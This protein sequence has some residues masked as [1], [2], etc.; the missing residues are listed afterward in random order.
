MPDIDGEAA[1]ILI[2][3]GCDPL[4]AA[5]ASTTPEPNSEPTGHKWPRVWVWIGAI[6]GVIAALVIHSALR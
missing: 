3:N 1:G 2:E 5:V 4:T 6:C